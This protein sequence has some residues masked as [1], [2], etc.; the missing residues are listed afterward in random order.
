MRLT[1]K[2]L[3][4]GQT[5]NKHEDIKREYKKK[6]GNKTACIRITSLSFVVYIKP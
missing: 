2:S 3:P 5:L 4:L 6:S 1:K